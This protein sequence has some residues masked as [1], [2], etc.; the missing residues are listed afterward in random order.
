MVEIVYGQIDV[1]APFR[2]RPNLIILCFALIVLIYES[3]FH[4]N[5]LEV[6]FGLLDCFEY[7]PLGSNGVC[8]CGASLGALVSP[9][10]M[11]F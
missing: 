11:S 8:V 7:F 4:L 10:N 3:R 6:K 9:Q 5:E 1:L 2:E